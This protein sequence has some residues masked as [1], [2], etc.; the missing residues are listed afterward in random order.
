MTGVSKGG[1][2]PFGTRLCEAKC[3]VLYLSARLPVQTRA[4]DAMR[5]CLHRQ[6]NGRV[7][8]EPQRAYLPPVFRERRQV[9]E[10]PAFLLGTK[11]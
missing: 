11:F 8:C 5:P 2:V 10:A 1:G 4:R 6:E 9:Y 7:M 3:S